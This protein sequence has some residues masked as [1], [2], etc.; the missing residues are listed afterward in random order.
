MLFERLEIFL[1][2]LIEPA[3]DPDQV[4]VDRD[5]FLMEC[6]RAD[7]SGGVFAD[8][9]QRKKLR[10]AHRDLA[11][12]GLDDF[13]GGFVEISPPGIV[14]QPFPKLQDIL[15]APLRERDDGGELLQ[16]TKIISPD[17]VDLG[18]LEHDL[19]KIDVIRRGILPPRHMAA[20]GI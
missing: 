6:D 8:A 3:I 5:F 2:I 7:G 18:L 19:R 17:R 13:E 16:E 20:V 12:E 4:A 10:F 11:S 1:A 14:A 15:F 9:W